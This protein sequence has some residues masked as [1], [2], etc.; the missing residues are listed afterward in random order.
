MPYKD[1]EKYLSTQKSYYHRDKESYKWRNIKNTYGLTKED[2]MSMLDKQDNKCALCK[3]P[4][5]GLS[6]RD[7][8]ID[9]CHTTNRVRG[10]LCMVC[11]VGLGMMGDNE[12]GLLKALSYVRG[13]LN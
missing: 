13:E 3:K 7:L 8:H 5:Q 4:F 6:Q 11:N 9:H 2:F 10:L 12:E 1:R